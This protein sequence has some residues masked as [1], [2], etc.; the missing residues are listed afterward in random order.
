VGT[1]ILCH[2]YSTGAADLTVSGGV[3]PYTYA[4]SNAAVSED[5]TNIPAGLYIVTITDANQCTHLDSIDITEPLPFVITVN[6]NTEICFGSSADLWIASSVNGAN[7]IDYLWSN[8]IHDS[9]ITVSPTQTTTYYA[10]GTDANGCPSNT[11]TVV[12]NVIQPMTVNIVTN[13]DSLCPGDLIQINAIVTGGHAPYT[14]TLP[15]G[16]V[17][18]MPY[19]VTPLQTTTYIINVSDSC[20]PLG[21]TDNVTVHVMPKPNVN[22]TSDIIAGCEDLTVSFTDDNHFMGQ[23]YVWDF[24]DGTYAYTQSPVHT[25]QNDGTYDITLTVTNIY[26]CDSTFTIHNM[27][28]VYPRPIAMFTPD[29]AVTSI[30]DPTINFYNNSINY[31]YS[32]WHFGDGSSSDDN[33]PQHTYGNTGVYTVQL[34]VTNIFGCSDSIT[35]EVTINND[36]TFYAPNAFTPNSDGHNETFNVYGVNIQPSSFHL[37]IYDRW[38]GLV[39]ESD[40]ITKGWDGTFANGTKIMQNNVFVW[41]ATFKDVF[42]LKHKETGTVTLLMENHD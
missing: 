2:G 21:V 35:G 16:T 40:D 37:S 34:T 11:D 5:L 14:Y 1:N 39:F 30:I 26:G 10:I 7:P 29:P 6:P 27:I 41:M 17:I 31:E 24:H 15:D 13:V 18:T 19:F 9:L 28:T 42:G 4:W 36:Y 3:P 32:H 38:G 33:Q 20:Q 12:V 22:I 8:G 25:F 23:T